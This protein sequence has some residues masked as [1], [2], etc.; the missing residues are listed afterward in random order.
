[1]QKYLNIVCF[2]SK[3]ILLFHLFLLPGGKGYKELC[4]KEG[5]GALL[6]SELPQQSRH[7]PFFFSLVVSIAQFVLALRYCERGFSYK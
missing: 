4:L 7:L 6:R 2:V 3:E 1:M 5:I